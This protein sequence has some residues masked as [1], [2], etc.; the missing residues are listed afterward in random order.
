MREVVPAWERPAANNRRASRTAFRILSFFT[1][2]VAT[3]ALTWR[4]GA[5]VV[6]VSGVP[7]P[8]MTLD[9]LPRVSLFRSQM[10]R[11]HAHVRVALMG[12]SMV[13]TDGP[14]VNMPEW[15]RRELVARQGKRRTGVHVINWAAWGTAPEYCMVDEI[16]EAKPDLLMLELNLRL[17]GPQPLG[18]IAYPEL[19][20][21]IAN[22]RLLEAA[23][24]PLS[25]AGVTLGRMLFYRGIVLAKREQ[26]FADVLTRQAM[27]FDTREPLEKWLDAKTH[28]HQYADLRLAWGYTLSA[29]YLAPDTARSRDS[30]SHAR[31]SLGDVIDGIG[32]DHPRLVVLQAMLQDFRKRGIPVLVWAS[33][34]N[35]DHLRRLG[36]R[37]DGIDRSMATIKRSVENSGARFIDLHALLRDD[38]FADASD[39]YMRDGSTSAA[40]RVGEQ[41]G[42]AITQ[43][44]ERLALQ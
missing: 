19:S 14:G 4:A 24:L 16:A 23:F 2:L 33:P 34:I 29:R 41:L 13:F 21:H 43:E 5:F 28:T 32:E 20:G 8:N 1:A 7:R 25:H 36:I 18:S 9:L 17:L 30:L 12:D 39:H 22:D 31:E 37:I 15:V 42:V 11:D 27:L 44:E 3:A 40:K 35:L 38:D 6:G 26:E 10:K